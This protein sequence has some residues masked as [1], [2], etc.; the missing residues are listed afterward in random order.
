MARP[1]R[2]ADGAPD[3]PADALGVLGHR[4]RE[5]RRR[6][7]LTLKELARRTGLSVPFLSQVE[8]G[9]TPSLASLFAL[10]RELDTTPEALLAGPAREDVAFVRADAGARYPYSDG[11]RPAVRRQLTGE[12]E[13]FSAA[14]YVAEPDADLGGFQA[15]PGR[16]LIYVVAGGLLVEIRTPSGLTRHALGPGDTL[17]YS[18]TDEHRWSVVGQETTRFLHV[19]SPRL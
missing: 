12:G 14:E 13:P 15:S 18:T 3:V 1:L 16:E 6:N 5:Q 11:E 10:A 4:L 7:N 19:L 2:A 17:A 8:N 9:K